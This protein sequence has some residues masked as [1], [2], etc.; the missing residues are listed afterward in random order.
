M[1]AMK[2][3]RRVLEKEVSETDRRR[4]SLLL[5]IFSLLL[6]GFVLLVLLELF[7]VGF[8]FLGRFLFWLGSFVF[9]LIL[10]AIILLAFPGFLFGLFGGR[11]RSRL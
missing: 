10:V 7:S 6:L 3:N 4:A 9:L 1:R 8:V 11:S 2:E 5:I